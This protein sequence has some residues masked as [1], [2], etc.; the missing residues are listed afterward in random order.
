MR[1]I[2]LI[3]GDLASGKSTYSKFLSTK[4]NVSLINKDRL[5][6]ILGDHIYT[7]NREENKRLSEISFSL[8]KYL[9]ETTKEDL[10]IES[11][12]K[13]YEMQELRKYEK[14]F[15]FLSLHFYGDNEILHKRFLKR[16]NEGR[17]YVHKSQDFSNIN[18][19]IVVLNDL[20][21]VKYIGDV[22]KVNATKFTDITEDAKL[23]T[24]VEKFLQKKI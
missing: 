9:I 7:S 17:H 15:E 5:K 10:I 13:S 14:D 22:I 18:D 11:N 19:F 23:L 8:I 2:I 12:F 24:S 16:L 20:R 21:N 3:G 1:K 6:E 4:F